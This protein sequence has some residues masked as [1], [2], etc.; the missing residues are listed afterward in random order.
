MGYGLIFLLTKSP[1]PPSEIPKRPFSQFH[2]K[3]EPSGLALPKRLHMGTPLLAEGTL[4][5]VPFYCQHN[6]DPLGAKGF[7]V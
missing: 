4:Q 5:G 7:R 1:V 6:W 3:W 2:A